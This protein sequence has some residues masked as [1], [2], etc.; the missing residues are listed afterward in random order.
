MPPDLI[1]TV[2]RAMYPNA[3]EMADHETE[4]NRDL[5]AFTREASMAHARTAIAV[6]LEA[7]AQEVEKIERM[8]TPGGRWHD[9]HVAGWIRSHT[10]QETA[11]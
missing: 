8:T 7:L 1:E 6:T 11:R 2:A 5:A 4:R 9:G 10:P 3:W